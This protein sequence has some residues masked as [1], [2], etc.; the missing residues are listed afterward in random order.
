M[1]QIDPE[2]FSSA[3]KV[4]THELTRQTDDCGG[5]TDVDTR[6]T[7]DATLDG[8]YDLD[9]ALTVFLTSYLCS[10]TPE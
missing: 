7:S 2:K 6:G 5:Y 10:D 4:F 1:V 3:M 9:K 8:H